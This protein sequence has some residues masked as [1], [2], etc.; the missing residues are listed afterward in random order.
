MLAAAALVACG[1]RTGLFGPLTSETEVDGGIPVDSGTPVDSGAPC[2]AGPP[3][4]AYALD[5]SGILHGHIVLLFPVVG[6]CLSDAERLIQHSIAILRDRN[7]RRAAHAQL[8]HETTGC[9]TTGSIAERCTV[10]HSV[11]R[12]WRTSGRNCC[13]Q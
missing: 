8:Q 1:A 10:L 12:G 4:L 13:A 7:V 2:E 5:G 3:Q 9:R 11:A 6:S